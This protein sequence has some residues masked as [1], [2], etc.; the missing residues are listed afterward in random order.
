MYGARS[1]RVYYLVLHCT[2]VSMCLCVVLSVCASEAKVYGH[3]KLADFFS[4]WF[5]VGVQ[6][7]I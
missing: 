6:D 3:S 1:F 7:L 5:L 4:S 2:H